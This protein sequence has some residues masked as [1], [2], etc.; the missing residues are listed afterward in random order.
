MVVQETERTQRSPYNSGSEQS[1]PFLASS[2]ESIDVDP[3]FTD[4]VIVTSAFYR[5]PARSQDPAVEL[6]A[7]NHLARFLTAKPSVVLD[8]LAAVLIPTCNAGSAGVTLEQR[9]NS[10]GGLQWVSVAGQLAPKRRD[11]I[12]PIGPTG[13]VPARQQAELF[14]RPERLYASL[15]QEPLRFEELLVAPWQLTSRRR[16]VI[17]I[18][19]HDAARRFDPEDLRLLQKLGDFANLAM[20]RNESN[21]NL[22]SSDA[23]A[24]ATRLANK[25]A[26]EVNNPLQA[27]INSLHLASPAVDDEH[28]LQARAQ[29]A[30]LADLVQSILE[31]KR[32]G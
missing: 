15:I 3:D 19:S 20:Q 13:T 6:A 8:E 31:V 24:S 7:V 27:L 29:A 10:C 9:R 21:E 28:L 17:W 14:R 4:E 5:R 22:R 23:L 12:S 16:G 30:R 2:H 26:H 1:L 25:L 11:G 32:T 18:A